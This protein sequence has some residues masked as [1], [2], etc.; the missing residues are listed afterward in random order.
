MRAVEERI[1]DQSV[2]RLLRAILR[3]GVMQ[4]AQVH[5]PVTGTPPGGVVSP[6]L[7]NVY[8]HRIDRAWDERKHGVLVRYADDAVVMCK[9]RQA[10][11]AFARLRVLLADLG[12][13]PKEAK[14]RTCTWRWAGK[15]STSSGSA[16]DWCSV[17]A[18]PGLRASPS[19]PAGPRRRRCSMPVTGSG[20]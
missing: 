10:E 20:N 12:L 15:G 14:T 19:L 5:R 9:S 11:A 2:L 18:E 3:A 6:L 17:R 8:L 13:E 1:C 7:A 16:T 4:D